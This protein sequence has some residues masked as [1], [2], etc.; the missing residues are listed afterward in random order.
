[1]ARDKQTFQ[2]DL[3][4]ESD[5][6]SVDGLSQEALQS[7]PLL[8]AVI[9]ESLRLFPPIGQLINRR[10]TQH[11]RLGG[12]ILIPEGTYVG[13][14]CYSTNRDPETWGPDAD[15]FRPTRWGV[16]CQEIQKE[17]RRRRA[18]AEFISFHGGQRACL[19]ERFAVLQLKV[20]LLVLV[21]ELKWKLDPSWPDRMTPV[22]K[23]GHIFVRPSTPDDTHIGWTTLSAQLASSVYR[24]DE[25]SQIVLTSFPCPFKTPGIACR[26]FGGS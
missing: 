4:E 8:S 17:Y 16:T 12:D 3:L 21:R 14:N 15:S 20:T 25:K 5:S 11:V 7:M 10:V 26:R 1:M 2:D 6:Y 23:F 22:S 18:R 24:A 13:Y 9:Y 19:G